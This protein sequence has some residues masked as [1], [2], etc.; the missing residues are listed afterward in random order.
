MTTVTGVRQ[1]PARQG[2]EG[3]IRASWV[4]MG[5]EEGEEG[6]GK[7]CQAVP[8]PPLQPFGRFRGN[9]RFKAGCKD[10]AAL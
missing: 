3:T 5:P 9:P 1:T 2:Q 7:S 6:S 8:S 10:L 4:E